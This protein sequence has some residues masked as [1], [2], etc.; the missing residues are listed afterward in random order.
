MKTWP[1]HGGP[2][3]FNGVIDLDDIDIR[4]TCCTIHCSRSGDTS[5]TR[6]GNPASCFY[7]RYVDT[8]GIIVIPRCEYHS[9]CDDTW[10]EISREELEK[11]LIVVATMKE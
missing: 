10:T 8:R 1:W 3:G 5:I 7:I 6:C 4:Q 11:L 2:S 9:G